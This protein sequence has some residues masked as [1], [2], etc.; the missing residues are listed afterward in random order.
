MKTFL[1]VCALL[2]CVIATVGMAPQQKTFEYKV[3]DGVSE[4]KINSLA[5]EGWE[6][7]STGNYGGQLAAPYIILRRPKG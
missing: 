4:K 2:L 3:E 1:I 6:P 7:V 5:N